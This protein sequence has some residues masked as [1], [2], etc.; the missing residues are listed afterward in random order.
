MARED[1]ANKLAGSDY[2][3]ALM[4][5]GECV[6]ENGEALGLFRKALAI[7]E[8]IS[9]GDSK[10]ARLQSRMAQ[11]HFDIG[12]RQ[13]AMDQPGA[14]LLNYR[15]GIAGAR[16]IAEEDPKDVQIRLTLTSAYRQEGRVLA[17]MGDSAAA[18]EVGRKAIQLASEL[19]PNNREPSR[20][21]TLLAE[22]YGALGETYAKAAG[23]PEAR[24]EACV[25]Y[26]QSAE[27]WRNLKNM[28]A[29]TVAQSA[30]GDRALTIS[31]RCAPALR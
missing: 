5:M 21:Y 30:M 26:G 24:R 1:P 4:H 11:L 23:N 16:K 2:A 8:P 3:T 29:L 18:I 17:A 28:G 14:A 12:Y 22:A 13:L 15:T 20:G 10:N 9:I 31:A 25:L 6:K 27:E 19:R 7:I